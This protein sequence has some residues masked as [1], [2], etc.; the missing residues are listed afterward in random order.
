MLSFSWQLPDDTEQHIL[1]FI[2]QNP[3]FGMAGIKVEIGHIV[4]MN[5]LLSTVV[6]MPVRYQIV[7]DPVEPCR[8][9]QAPI[10]VISD[11]MHSS[12]KYP[13]G[14]ILSVV[15]VTGPIVNVG[16]DPPDI[17]LI[18]DTKGIPIT[19]GGPLEDQVFWNVGP[20]QCEFV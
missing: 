13:G 11:M 4:Q 16:I 20:I 12:Q 10:L 9:R 19:R 8:K 6:P 5:F 18:K 1:V 14:Q 2:S 3:G 7:G 17:P 15:M